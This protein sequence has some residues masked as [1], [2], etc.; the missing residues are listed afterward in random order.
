MDLGLCKKVVEWSV[1]LLDK[2]GS[3]REL[4]SSAYAMCTAR[5]LTNDVIFLRLHQRTLPARGGQG[6]G[7]AANH[8]ST[9]SFCH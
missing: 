7:V 4:L 6:G 1:L 9:P 2:R 3:K 8:C 5:T